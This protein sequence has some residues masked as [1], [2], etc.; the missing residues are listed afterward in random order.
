MDEREDNVDDDGVA[1][2]P[3]EEKR[4]IPLLMT[5]DGNIESSDD[6]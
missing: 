5:I 1:E 4:V 2:L 3:H 6:E